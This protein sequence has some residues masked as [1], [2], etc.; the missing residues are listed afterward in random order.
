[1]AATRAAVEAS[2]AALTADDA[3]TLGLPIAVSAYAFVV[4]AEYDASAAP[5]VAVFFAVLTVVLMRRGDTS[6]ALAIFARWLRHQD[7]R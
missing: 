6:R 5:F 2:G 7:E 4:A 1:V 3:A